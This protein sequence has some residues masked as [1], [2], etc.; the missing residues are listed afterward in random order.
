MRPIKFAFPSD[1]ENVTPPGGDFFLW[2]YTLLCDDESWIE[3]VIRASKSAAHQA[4]HHPEVC[5][6]TIADAVYSRGQ[7]VIRDK[8]LNRDD[9]WLHWVVHID[10]IIQDD[11]ALEG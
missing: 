4:E 9:P 7:T 8:I 11:Y 5:R 2:R 1:P 6:P 3:S 10:G